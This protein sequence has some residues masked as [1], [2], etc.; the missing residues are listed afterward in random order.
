MSKVCH[1]HGWVMSHTW[2]SHV[3]H[4]DESG[5][6]HT[7][8]NHVSYKSVVSRM[9]ESCHTYEWVM[10]HIW[11]SHVTYMNDPHLT[12]E[13]WK[14]CSLPPFSLLL[15][16]PCSLPP[17]SLLL[18]AVYRPHFLV[19]LPL[20]LSS[21][22]IFSL[23]LPHL[24]FSPPPPLLCASKCSNNVPSVVA[25]VMQSEQIAT[26]RKKIKL[27]ATKIEIGEGQLRQTRFVILPFPHPS[28]ICAVIHMHTHMQTHE[29]TCTHTLTHTLTQTLTHTRT[30]TRT[31]THTHTC[32]QKNM[33]KSKKKYP[34]GIQNSFSVSICLFPS[35]SLSLVFSFS[36]SLSLSFTPMISLSHNLTW[37]VHLWFKATENPPQI[38]PK[39]SIQ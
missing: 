19:S 6:S 13:L 37:L 3:T 38:I 35:L 39:Q 14:P 25:Y 33:S 9:K 16:K 21:Q 28:I 32:I 8:M 1:T 17:F 5:M 10:S 27:F 36:L 24:P 7:W 29:H 30:H 22:L 2:M 15:W 23:P 11:M 20:W 34:N 12:N 26:L 31:H 4:M 18:V